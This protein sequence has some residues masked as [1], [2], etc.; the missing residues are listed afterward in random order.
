VETP[1]PQDPRVHTW[2]TQPI[3]VGDE[4]VPHV[5]QNPSE[6]AGLIAPDGKPYVIA[7]QPFTPYSDQAYVVISPNFGGGVEWPEPSF[8]P[9]TGTE[10]VCTNIQSSAYKA[11]TDR[12]AVIGPINGFG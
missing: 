12:S 11:G 7:T 2:P 10:Y 5:V 3:P 1:V 8:S 9:Q 4:L 6:W